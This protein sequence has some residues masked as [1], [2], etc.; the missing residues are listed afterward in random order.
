MVLVAVARYSLLLVHEIL[1]LVRDIVLCETN[2]LDALILIPLSR[3][4]YY[5]IVT[6]TVPY[7]DGTFVE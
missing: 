7:W 2:D 5:N 1:G 3:G 4:E 6:S